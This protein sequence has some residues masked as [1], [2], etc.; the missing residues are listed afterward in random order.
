[1]CCVW[2]VCGMVC[3]VCGVCG[4]CCVLCADVCVVWCLVFGVCIESSD[5]PNQAL[6]LS[7]EDKTATAQGESFRKLKPI[8]KKSLLNFGAR[9]AGLSSV[10]CALRLGVNVGLTKE[11][12]F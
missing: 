6:N 3:G 5:H 11:S 4:V 12:S 9:T 1:M 7:A 10:L 2:G 8:H